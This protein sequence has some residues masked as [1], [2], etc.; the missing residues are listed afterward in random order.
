[1]FILPCIYDSFQHEIIHSE[2]IDWAKRQIKAPADRERY[3]LYFHRLHRT[4]V[5]ARWAENKYGIFTDFLHI[6]TSLG[7]FDGSMAKEFRRRLYAPVSPEDITKAM[8]DAASETQVENDNKNDN[9]R[10]FRRRRSG[11][12]DIWD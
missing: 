1:M 3:F 4:F 7:F 8:K 12:R 11:R 2:I 10:N 5:I 9:M 6:G